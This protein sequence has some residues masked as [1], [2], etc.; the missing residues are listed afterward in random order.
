M[1]SSVPLSITAQN[2]SLIHLM[3]LDTSPALVQSRFFEEPRD[4]VMEAWTVNATSNVYSLS[5]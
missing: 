3:R 4:Y 5:D 2:P 1:I